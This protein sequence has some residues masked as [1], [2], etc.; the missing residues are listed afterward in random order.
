M[1]SSY[2]HQ[3]TYCNIIDCMYGHE[4][5]YYSIIIAPITAKLSTY[6]RV[7]RTA[8]LSSSNNNGGRPSVDGSPNHPW[9]LPTRPHSVNRPCSVREVSVT[10]HN[11][12]IVHGASTV[13]QRTIQNDSNIR[14]RGLFV[15]PTWTVHG[16]PTA[17]Y[18]NDDPPLEGCVLHICSVGY[19]M[20]EASCSN[21]DMYRRIGNDI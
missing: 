20:P 12:R 1:E 14:N 19:D 6:N 2:Q 13:R 15:K 9:S 21:L 10:R 17:S 7:N 3:L 16:T 8:A 11:Q 18:S 5:K 4:D